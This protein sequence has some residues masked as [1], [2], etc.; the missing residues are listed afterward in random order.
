MYKD[1]GL[2]AGQRA[3]WLPNTP[4]TNPQTIE[5][6]TNGPERNFMESSGRKQL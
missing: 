6:Q 5:A 2:T 1:M 4:W 3:H